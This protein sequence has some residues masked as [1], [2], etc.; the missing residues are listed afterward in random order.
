ML[1]CNTGNTD[2]TEYRVNAII[3]GTVTVF[4]EAESETEAKEKAERGD[5]LDSRG[6]EWEVDE[7]MSAHDN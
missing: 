4:V 6:L 3:I 2:M 1:G 7:V 5:W